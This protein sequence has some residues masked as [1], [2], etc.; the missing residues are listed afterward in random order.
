M[1]SDIIREV[2][3]HYALWFL[4]YDHDYHD[5]NLCRGRGAYFIFLQFFL[6]SVVDLDWI[7]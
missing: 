3:V 1:T 6:A 7:I 2:F 4:S 5:K